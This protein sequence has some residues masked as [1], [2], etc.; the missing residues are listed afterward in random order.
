MTADFHLYEEQILDHEFFDMPS[1]A[2]S[3]HFQQVNG[4]W[5]V[6]S[7]RIH[8]PERMSTVNE[9]RDAVE[10]LADLIG[11]AG[12]PAEGTQVYVSEAG[13]S[14]VLKG[15]P[16]ESEKSGFFVHLDPVFEFITELAKLEVSGELV[17]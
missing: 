3:I 15:N 4:R 17:D 7:L 16:A 9:R 2:G 14:H 12:P 10:D 6:S 13:V 11:T 1:P 8:L 5:G